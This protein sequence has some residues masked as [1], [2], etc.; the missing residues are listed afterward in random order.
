MG[1]PLHVVHIKSIIRYGYSQTLYPGLS[2]HLIIYIR[3]INY[4][5]FYYEESPSYSSSL[6]TNT[7]LIFPGKKQFFPASFLCVDHKK[8]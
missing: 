5:R 2:Y 7:L 8:Y 6:I 3:F 1:Q 4:A